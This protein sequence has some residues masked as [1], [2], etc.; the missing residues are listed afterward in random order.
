MVLFALFSRYCWCNFKKKI[1]RQKDG[2]NIRQVIQM[3]LGQGNLN[4][5]NDLICAGVDGRVILKLIVKSNVAR[6]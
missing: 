2:A 4:G 1:R 5:R 6:T 3:K